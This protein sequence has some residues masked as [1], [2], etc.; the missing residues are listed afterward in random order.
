MNKLNVTFLALSPTVFNLL[1]TCL[2]C[3]K[4]LFHLIHLCSSLCLH[5]KIYVRTNYMRKI[6]ARNFTRIFYARKNYAS[7]FYARKFYMYINRVMNKDKMEES[8]KERGV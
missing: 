6:Y 1:Y 3:S 7:S 4:R 5:V 8:G 2:S